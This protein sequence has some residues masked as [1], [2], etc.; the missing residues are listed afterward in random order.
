MF[1]KKFWKIVEIPET[2]QYI[3]EKTDKSMKI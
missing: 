1:L 3:D 2:G